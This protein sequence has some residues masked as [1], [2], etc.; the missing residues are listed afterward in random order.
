MPSCCQGWRLLNQLQ[1]PGGRHGNDLL[2]IIGQY[3]MIYRF[4]FRINSIDVV[5][6]VARDALFVKQR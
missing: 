6:D 2:A 3:C 4:D 1:P 5:L